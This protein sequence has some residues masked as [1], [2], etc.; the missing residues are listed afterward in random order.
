M[1]W[2][3][4]SGDMVPF[5]DEAQLREEAVAWVIRLHRGGVS[6]EEREALDAWC[7]QSPAHARMFR[8]VSGVWESPELRE[9]A[10]TVVDSLPSHP[11]T[12]FNLRWAT[13]VVATVVCMVVLAMLAIQF[14]VVTRWR[15][16]HRTEAG[17]RRTIELP[18]R[19]IVTLNTQ[20]AIA[21]SFDETA[22]RIHVLSGEAFFDV[23]QDATRPFIVEG[24]ETSVRATG[25]T[26]V[27]RAEAGG[28]Q[29]TVIE[30]AVE[31]GVNSLIASPAIVTAGSQ[32]QSEH[33]RLGPL[34]AVDVV[35]ASAWLR[36][37]LVVHGIS[38]AHVLEELRRYYPG[39]VVLV[40]QHVGRVQVTGTYSVEDPVGALTLLVKTVPL[41]MISL[42]D[43]LVIL[44]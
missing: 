22:R 15:A 11:K 4:Q 28:D 37:R 42:T 34:H 24:A 33:G 19:S 3:D 7:G 39:T 10:A 23:R 8:K 27:V 6:S 32:V 40:N 18:D 13:F 41:S 31:V 2:T 16:D 20:S 29:V 43:R 26:F 36:G 9:A 12:I 35:S 25:T 30:G 17:E 1:Q 14:D 21:V 44:F 38:F 5:K